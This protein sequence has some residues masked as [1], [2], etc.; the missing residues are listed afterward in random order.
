MA[1]KK[2]ILT[3]L[4]K[5]TT[6]SIFLSSLLSS[7][8]THANETLAIETKPLSTLNKPQINAFFLGDSQTSG[9]AKEKTTHSSVSALATI[10]PSV[11]D[12]K[13]NLK[14]NGESGRTLAGT[15]QAYM[16]LSREEQQSLDWVHFQESGNQLSGGGTQNTP[17]KFAGELKNFILNIK[18][19]SP[20]A[21]I[22]TETAYSFEAEAIKGR[23]WTKYNEILNQTIEE[24][25]K[26]NIY[27][28]VAQVDANIKS[29]VFNMQRISDRKRGQEAVWGDQDN[30]IKRHYTGLGN[31]MVGLSI[32]K[33]IGLDTNA[34]KLS[35][36]PVS[37]ITPTKKDLL[38][39]V[40]T[41]K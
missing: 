32:L 27:V 6:L 17:Q 21:T 12:K 18:Q 4:K 31:T 41:S 10:W 35:N 9:R 25:R 16:S 11:S 26:Q 5:L 22:S 1:I 36:I 15:H 33:A 20:K 14:S 2:T 39:K 37:E 13:L 7:Q 28:Y 23:D 30:I 29:L 19:H 8:A 40:L 24:L 38:L 34:I 3:L